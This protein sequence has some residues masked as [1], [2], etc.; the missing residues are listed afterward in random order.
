MSSD[1]MYFIGRTLQHCS[2][3][4][5][6]SLP[7]TVLPLRLC[8][9]PLVADAEV[10]RFSWLAFQISLVSTFR[11]WRL[12]SVV[13]NP[14][15][16]AHHHYYICHNTLHS[17]SFNQQLRWAWITNISVF[18]L[19]SKR[20]PRALAGFWRRPYQSRSALKNKIYCSSPAC[21]R[22]APPPLHCGGCHSF[23]LFFSQR[24]ERLTRSFRTCS[25][26]SSTPGGRWRWSPPALT[27]WWSEPGSSLHSKRELR[28]TLGRG[29]ALWFISTE[30][31]PNCDSWDFNKRI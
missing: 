19:S 12:G 26:S 28:S 14:A 23:F 1:W 11:K 3:L 21:F 22:P 9:F 29:Q 4:S 24:T 15:V 13:T 5:L 16:T 31:H 27:W 8:V 30:A 18:P 20:Q 25:S 7:R 6:T 10:T 2:P 17:S